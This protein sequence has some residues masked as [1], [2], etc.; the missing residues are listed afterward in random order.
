MSKLLLSG[1]M[2][3]AGLSVTACASLRPPPEPLPP[4]A[5]IIIQA[6]A[7]PPILIPASC[8]E[9]PSA[10]PGVTVREIYPEDELT[11]LDAAFED[12]RIDYARLAGFADQLSMQINGCADGLEAQQGVGAE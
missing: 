10:R 9:R 4:P 12:L 8:L 3:L 6:P 1:V 2:S 7:P 11:A 5:P